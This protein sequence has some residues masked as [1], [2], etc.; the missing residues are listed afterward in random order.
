MHDRN[1]VQHII[2]RALRS[3]LL[4]LLLAAAGT[5]Q[6]GNSSGIGLNLGEWTYWSPDLPMIDQFKRADGWLTQCT[7]DQNGNCPQAWAWDTGE[8]AKLKLDANGWVTQLP[9]A[10]D[11]NTQYRWV[12][13]LLF[14]DNGSGHPSGDYVVLYDGEGQLDYALLGRKDTAHSRPNRDVVKVSSGSSGLLVKLMQTNPANPLRNIRVIPPGGVCDAAPKDYADSAAACAVRGTGSFVPFETLVSTQA[15]HPFFLSDMRG[16]RTLRFLDW[17]R[18]NDSTLQNWAERPKMANAFWT[19][20]YGVPIEAMVDAADRSAA[21]PWINVPTR[22]SD[23]YVRR[24]ARLVKARMNARRTLVVEYSNEPWNG[25]FRTTQDYLSA[26]ALERWPTAGGTNFEKMMSW[27]GLRA[28]QVC[29]IVKAEFGSEAGR[30][31]CVANGQL[32]SADV[33]RQILECRHYA[34]EPGGK[35][36]A[37]SFDAV[38]IAPYVGGYIGESS[39][40]GTVDSWAADGDGGVARL[41]AEMLGEDIDGQPV[42]PPLLGKHGDSVPGG[43]IERTRQWVAANAALAASKGLPL[44]G[45]EGGQHLTTFNLGDQDPV[46]I[47]MYTRANRDPRMARTYERLLQNWRAVGGQTL[48]LFNYA[49]QPT[50]SGAWGLKE[51]QLSTEG[52]K[53]NAVLPWRDSTPCWW[54]GCG[55]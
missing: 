24:F 26:R 52:V 50:R 19:G 28:A 54:T 2:R 1:P 25:Q 20:R 41:F 43:A 4:A 45:Y 17:A 15:W 21:D 11:M 39:V 36:C 55:R 3:P 14:K 44:W 18:T 12:A 40:R 47:A 49:Y 38:A 5:A 8:Q 32:G 30:V 9:A 16:F 33:T 31:K 53:W 22:A 23:D 42:P 10:N 13:A 29:G 7:Q 48:A 51:T 35:P 27:Y 37:G 6:A 46:W 34:S